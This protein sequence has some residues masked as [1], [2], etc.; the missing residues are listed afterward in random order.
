MMV[1][2]PTEV[3]ET[4]LADAGEPKAQGLAT[5]TLGQAVAAG[6]AASSRNLTSHMRKPKDGT[7]R[8]PP[9]TNGS[10]SS[11]RKAALRGGFRFLTGPA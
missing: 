1:H 6:T 7:T 11:N 10:P 4:T 3:G 2:I 5:V 9:T 8:A